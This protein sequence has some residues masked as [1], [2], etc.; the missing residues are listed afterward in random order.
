M[1]AEWEV[2]GDRASGKKSVGV[3]VEES[4]LPRIRASDCQT[5]SD[6]HSAG[7]KNNTNKVP[8]H[9]CACGRAWQNTQD[10]VMWTSAIYLTRQKVIR[11]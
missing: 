3:W 8:E 11:R 10:R 4:K 5:E 7:L 6:V 2:E 9:S 1:A